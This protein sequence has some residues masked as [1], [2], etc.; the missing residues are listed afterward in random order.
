MV[1]TFFMINALFV[2]VVFLL[3]LQK[4]I[5]HVNWPINPKENF[6]YITDHNEVSKF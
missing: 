5:L 2:L 1:M 6:T 4:D 3:T